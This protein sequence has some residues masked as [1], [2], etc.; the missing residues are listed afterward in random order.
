MKTLKKNSPKQHNVSQTDPG[1]QVEEMNVTYWTKWKPK[2]IQL[3]LLD[4]G[5][6]FMAVV[7]ACFVEIILKSV[8]IKSKI[9]LN[10]ITHHFLR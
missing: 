8:C 1:I 3:H 5:F 7:V 2:E 9:F 6:S 4:F 10:K